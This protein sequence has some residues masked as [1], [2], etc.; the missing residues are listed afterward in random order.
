MY[1]REGLTHRPTGQQG[2][3][4][5]RSGYNVQCTGQLCV[6]MS[7]APAQGAEGEGAE[8]EGLTATVDPFFPTPPVSTMKKADSKLATERV[9]VMPTAMTLKGSPSTGNT[10]SQNPV[11]HTPDSTS[12]RI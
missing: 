6:D 10:M 1:K 8:G 4:Y 11:P 2:N 7:S 12:D 5:L 3:C 9:I